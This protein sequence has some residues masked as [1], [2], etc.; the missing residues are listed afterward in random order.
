MKVVGINGSP[1]Q[2]GNTAILIQTVFSELNQKGIETELIHL[3]KKTIKGCTACWSCMTQKNGKCVMSDD[4]FNDCFEQMVAADGIILGS[5][6]YSAGVT[7]Q[8]KAFIDR[9]SVVLA[10]NK[11]LLK[12]K[13]GASVIAVRRGGAISAFDT[14]THFLHSKE[15]FLVGST[16]WNMVYGRDIGEVEQDQEGIAN[17]KN[18][19][20]NMAWLLQKIHGVS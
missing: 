19:G 14:L 5:P 15:M 4:Y 13:V 16:Y 10:A 1:R 17:M 3:A 7:S 18:L 2:E 6:V 11:G 8:I 12:H 9:A 20:Q